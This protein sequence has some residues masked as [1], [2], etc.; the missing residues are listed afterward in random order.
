SAYRFSSCGERASVWHISEM[1]TFRCWSRD[2]RTSIRS[3]LAVKSLIKFADRPIK[4]MPPNWP[5]ANGQI[6]CGSRNESDSDL[7]PSLL[8][9]HSFLPTASR[10]TSDG[11][12]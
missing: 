8:G 12:R 10:S 3:E 1:G 2:L 6:A 4:K 7:I 9:S 5:E 11:G